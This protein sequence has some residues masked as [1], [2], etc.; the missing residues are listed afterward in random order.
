MGKELIKRKIAIL[1]KLFEGKTKKEIRDK[2]EKAIFQTA[3]LK[4]RNYEV[5]VNVPF[6]EYGGSNYVIVTVYNAINKADV[7]RFVSEKLNLPEPDPLSDEEFYTD[8]YGIIKVLDKGRHQCYEHYE[9]QKIIED[10]LKYYVQEFSE[11]KNKVI[12]NREEV[13]NL[14]KTKYNL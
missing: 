6:D 4:A 11:I 7:I 2:W 1:N 5:H 13:L 9:V 10:F 8:D 14:L 3:D 12:D